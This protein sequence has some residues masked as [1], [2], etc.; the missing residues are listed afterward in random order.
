[1]EHL[2]GNF[3][4]QTVESVLPFIL[5]IRIKNQTQKVSTEE[6]NENDKTNSSIN[7]RSTS[8]LILKS[9]SVAL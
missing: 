3:E 1:M 7:T 2:F 4:I 9:K 8:H 5:P 6:H